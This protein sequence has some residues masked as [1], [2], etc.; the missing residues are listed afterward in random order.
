MPPVHSVQLHITTT[1]VAA[2]PNHAR[3]L[4]QHFHDTKRPSMAITTKHNSDTQ[5]CHVIH[6]LALVP[7]RRKSRKMTQQL[8]WRREGPEGLR[9]Q[10]GRGKNSKGKYLFPPFAFFSV[11]KWSIYFLANLLLI[12]PIATLLGHLLTFLGEFF[13]LLSPFPPVFV[14]FPHSYFLFSFFVLHLFSHLFFLFSF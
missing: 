13:S 5:T 11:L 10:L 12:G 8:N 6:R 9:K 14:F 1:T 2:L 7:R 4:I 3:N